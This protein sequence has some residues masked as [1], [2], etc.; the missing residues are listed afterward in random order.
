MTTQTGTQAPT[1]HR[2]LTVEQAA[3]AQARARYGPHILVTRLTGEP[4]RS[5]YFQ[6]H[7]PAPDGERTPIGASFLV[8]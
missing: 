8:S 7:A 2:T 1:T 4:G 5:G 6:A 3:S